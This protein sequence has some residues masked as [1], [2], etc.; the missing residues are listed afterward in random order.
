MFLVLGLV[1]YGGTQGIAPNMKPITTKY[2]QI[3]ESD[4]VA[5]CDAEYTFIGTIESMKSYWVKNRVGKG[6]GTIQRIQTALRFSVERTLKG[7]MMSTQEIIVPG[8]KV[9]DVEGWVVGDTHLLP[10][11]VVGYR[12][13]IAFDKTP[14]ETN[15]HQKGQAQIRAL[16]WIPAEAELPSQKD[17]HKEVLEARSAYCN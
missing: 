11:S 4:V 13:M 14:V 9:G 8:G 1:S 3:P 2:G 10:H 7:T 12:Y 5:I 16:Y 17:L 15:T 6:T